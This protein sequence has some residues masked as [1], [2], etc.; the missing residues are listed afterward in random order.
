MDIGTAKPTVEEQQAAPHH[1]IDVVDPDEHYSAGRYAREAAG[2]I[3]EVERRGRLPIVVGGSGFYIKALTEGL[4]PIPDVPDEVRS[5]LQGEARQDLPAL[6]RRLHDVDPALA[7]Q[8]HPHDTQRIVRGLEVQEVT[9]RPLSELQAEPPVP[10]GR[11]DTHTFAL[12]MERETL[13]DRISARVDRMLGAGLVDEVEDLQDRGYGPWL[14]ALN[15]F[16]YREV[17]AVLDGRVA[18][19][20]AAEEIKQGTRR[21]AKRQLTWL[22]GCG[23]PAWVDP[24]QCNAADAIADTF[25]SAQKAGSEVGAESP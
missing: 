3:R 1:M 5:R 19:S 17:F 18:L 7:Q 6:Y 15:T 11:W 14:K 12:D 8:L 2:A 25:R 20:D 9:G 21:Y 22:R 13:Y 4:A 10:P 16:G 23:H 24:T